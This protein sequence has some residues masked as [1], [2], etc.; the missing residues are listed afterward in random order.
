MSSKHGTAIDSSPNEESVGALTPP[1][2][3]A[4]NAPLF[5]ATCDIGTLRGGL[6]HQLWFLISHFWL[7]S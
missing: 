7:L 5:R 1:A 6:R 3:A 2:L 4:T